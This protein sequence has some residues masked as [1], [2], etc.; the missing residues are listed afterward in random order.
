MTP[1]DADIRSAF[2]A[3]KA[4]FMPRSCEG[5]EIDGVDLILLDADAAGCVSD[6]LASGMQ[7]EEDRWEILLA[8]AGQ[9]RTVV[10]HLQGEERAY[11]ERLRGLVDAVAARHGG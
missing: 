4:T 2:E 3:H 11:F 1:T 7:L 8:C 6:F 9:L 10:P 5:K